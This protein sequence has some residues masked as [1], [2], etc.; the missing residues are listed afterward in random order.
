MR[1]ASASGKTISRTRNPIPRITRAFEAR[2]AALRILKV[3]GQWQRWGDGSNMLVANFRGLEFQYRT[4]FQKPARQPVASYAQALLGVPY[5]RW[6][7]ALYIYGAPE[8]APNG[9]GAILS[10]EWNEKGE[11]RM[12]AFRNGPWEALLLALADD[13]ERTVAAH[14]NRFAE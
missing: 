13:A 6:P 14:F 5:Y 8:Y 4:P 7:Y 11:A 9:V 2:A 10:L 3:H 12:M 1:N